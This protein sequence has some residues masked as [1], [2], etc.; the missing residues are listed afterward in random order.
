M[1]WLNKLLDRGGDKAPE[2]AVAEDVPVCEHVALVARWESAEDI[3]KDERASG[4][5]C[6]ACG[7]E[8]TP[9]EAQRLR[10][11]EAARI[12]QRIGD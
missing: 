12:K 2:A 9:T 7:A 8:F 10:A 6:E 4:Y 5:K 11:T 3:G 1:K